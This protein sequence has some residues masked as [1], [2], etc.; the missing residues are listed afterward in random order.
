MKAIERLSVIRYKSKIN[1]N[2]K[3]T[4][5]FRILRKE[6]IWVVAHENMKKHPQN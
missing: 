4:E 5:I 3:H 2:W 1:K 6:D